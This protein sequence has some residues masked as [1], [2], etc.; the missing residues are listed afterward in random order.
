MRTLQTRVR[1][2]KAELDAI[3][4]RADAHG[5]HVST[6]IHDATLA[7]CNSDTSTVDL[8]REVRTLRQSFAGINSTLNEAVAL[9]REVVAKHDPQV[10]ARIAAANKRP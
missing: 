1:F 8:R 4:A 5:K 7:H 3:R 9:L 10:V 2:T 6:V